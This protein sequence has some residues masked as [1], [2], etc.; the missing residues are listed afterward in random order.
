MMTD[1]RLKEIAVYWKGP[2][3]TGAIKGSEIGKMAD[4]LLLLRAEVKEA[5]ELR[6]NMAGF[7]KAVATQAGEPS[8]CKAFREYDEAVD[9]RRKAGY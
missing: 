8:L 7:L 4:E 3:L 2:G 5:A 1:E 9:T 6:L